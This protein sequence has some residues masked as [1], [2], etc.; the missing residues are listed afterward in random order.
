M[1]EEREPKMGSGRRAEK[2]G[3]FFGSTPPRFCRICRRQ[4]TL[5]T[6]IQLL[7]D[8]DWIGNTNQH[9]IPLRMTT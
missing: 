1:H 6:A 3:P 5:Q 7:S 8:A 9:W 2:L 4:R